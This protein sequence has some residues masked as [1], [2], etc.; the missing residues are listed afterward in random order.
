MCGVLVA[1]A[2]VLQEA[3]TAIGAGIEDE[4][5]QTVTVLPVTLGGPLAAA[6]LGALAVEALSARGV[7]GVVVPAPGSCKAEPASANC[8]NDVLR[9]LVLN[10]AHVA[11]VPVPAARPLHALL[12]R[13]FGLTELGDV[14]PAARLACYAQAPP[15]SAAS[16][17]P[18]SLLDFADEA[19]AAQYRVPYDDIVSAVRATDDTDPFGYNLY[20]LQDNMILTLL[21]NKIVKNLCLQVH[22][23]CV[24]LLEL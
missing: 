12:L 19:V 24:K 4:V 11:L 17:S 18:R 1:C 5:A 13:D 7:R 8:T 6:A 16:S 3:G 22:L 21:H 2:L 14:M 20:I 10:R 9:A 15:P 23:F